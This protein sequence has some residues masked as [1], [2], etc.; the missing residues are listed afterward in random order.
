VD[1]VRNPLV[2]AGIEVVLILLLVLGA[3]VAAAVVIWLVRR[4]GPGR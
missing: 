1:E 3:L 2:P 4:S